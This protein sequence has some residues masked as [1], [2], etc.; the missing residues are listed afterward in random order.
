VPLRRIASTDAKYLA[1]T[2]ILIGDMSDINYEFLLFDRPVIL[3]ANAWLR[4]HF[5]DIGIKTDLDGLENAIHRS[6]DSP[7]EYQEQRQYWLKKTTHLP[8]GRSSRRVLQT[9]IERSGFTKPRWFFPHGNNT[10]RRQMLLPLYEEAAEEGF[11]AREI[12]SGPYDESVEPTIYVGANNKNLSFAGGFKVHID[13]GLKGE[14]VLIMEREI[15]HYRNHDYFPHVDLHVTEGQCAFETTKAL[16]GPY[17]DRAAMVGYARSDHL[18]RH[19][20]AENRAAV[21]KEL[22]FDSARPLITYAP[23]GGLREGKPG[24]SLSDEV[25]R[26][27]NRISKENGHNVLVKLKYPGPSWLVTLR[28]RAVAAAARAVGL[29]RSSVG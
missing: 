21:F 1:A 7:D 13:H 12:V 10:V 23:A 3:L 25:L 24:G 19:N 18:L 22:R 14:G 26:A 8:D 6:I 9:I 16:L 27:L 2:D 20:T 5:P 11:E 15:A 29:R 4:E 28:Q 17:Q